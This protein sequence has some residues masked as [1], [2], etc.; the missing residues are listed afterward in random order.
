MSDTR[1]EAASISH[2][3]R[4]WAVAVIAC[5]MVLELLDMTILN[6]AIPTLRQEFGASPTQ[7]Q[8]MVAGYTTAFALFLITGGRLGDI[9]GYRKML[10]TGMAGFTLSSLMCGF[11]PTPDSLIAARL[12]QGLTGALMVPQGTSLVQV[13]FAPQDRMKP[14]ALYGLLGGIATMLGPIIGGGLIEADVFGLSWRP[15]FLVNLP[16]GLATIALGWR[17]LPE[18]KSPHAPRLDMR[19]MMLSTLTLFALLFPLIQAPHSGWPLWS[20]VLLILAL[21]LALLLWRHSMQMEAHNAS[22]MIVPGLF[23]VRGFQVGLSVSL[24]F[25]MAT[26][27]FMFILPITLQTGLG[28][29]AMQSGFVHMPLAFFIALGIGFLSRR[30]LPGTGIAMLPCGIVIMALGYGWLALVVAGTPATPTPLILPM[31]LTG[32]GMGFVM[33]PLPPFTLSDVDVAHAG[34]GSGLMKTVQQLGSAMG[35]AIIG[36]VYF[37]LGGSGSGAIIVSAFLKSLG[38]IA[39]L[40]FAAG[41]LALRFPRDLKL[42][43]PRGS[44]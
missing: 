25:Q 12:L 23:S 18:G 33:G 42:L 43:S 27:G 13:M 21:P 36:N 4:L 34:A 1:T 9:F 29:S 10:L 16:I 17:F 30:M 26:T 14:L 7:I 5:V 2:A 35:V 20:I 31:S 19:G 11:A 37:W 6:V 39:I 8:W 15:G 38:G 3:A 40:L 24:L 22:P 28:M 44:P 41:L 32:L